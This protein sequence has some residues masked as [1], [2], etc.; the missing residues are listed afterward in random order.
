MLKVCISLQYLQQSMGDEVDFL[1]GYKHKSLLQAD[2]IT[3]GVHIQ[4]YLK[5]PKQHV[6]NIFATCQR[7]HEG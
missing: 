3:F 4:A 2:S 6:Y 7:K 1:P 5:C